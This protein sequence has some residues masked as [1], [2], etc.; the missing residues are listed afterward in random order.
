VP[1]T[2]CD[3]NIQLSLYFWM[4]GTVLSTASHI[5]RLLELQRTDDV[6]YSHWGFQDPELDPIPSET[7]IFTYSLYAPP[8]REQPYPE[9][10]ARKVIITVIQPPW[11]LGDRD[12][13]D[14]TE[15]RTVCSA[16]WDFLFISVSLVHLTVSALRPYED[17][18]RLCT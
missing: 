12:I 8:I 9:D 5:S 6:E 18:R 15:I 14:L 17:Q 2:F 13:K 16:I 7:M 10:V 1:F 4:K 3:V 11:V